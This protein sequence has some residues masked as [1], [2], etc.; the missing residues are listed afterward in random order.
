MRD[1]SQCVENLKTLILKT[2]L[3]LVK[4]RKLAS[5]LSENDS[6]TGT[7]VLNCVRILTRVLPYVYECD[8]LRAWEDSFFWERQ[9]IREYGKYASGVS[10]YLDDQQCL[11]MQVVQALVELLFYTGF[12]LP[13]PDQDAQG[14]RKGSI[15][16]GLWQSGIACDTTVITSKELESKRTEILQ[17]LLTLESKSIY[18]T[19]SEHR[20]NTHVIRTR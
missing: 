14:E 7:E 9:N 13:W 1:D 20:N 8:S 12:T 3:A 18:I 11:G 17:L 4:H 6:K 10:D 16:Y 2:A 5:S 19:P 15:S